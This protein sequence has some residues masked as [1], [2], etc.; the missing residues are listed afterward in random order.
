MSLISIPHLFVLVWCRPLQLPIVEITSPSLPAPLLRV[1]AKECLELAKTSPEPAKFQIIY[2]HI[3]NFVQSNLFLSCWK[4]VKQVAG[5]CE[6]HGKIGLKETEGVLQFR[7]EG[8]GGY[9]QNFNIKVPYMYPEDPLEIIFLKS[10][11]PDDMQRMSYAQAEAMVARCVAGI[12]P[13]Y[14]YQ[15]TQ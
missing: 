9:F 10:H 5:L 15:V 3:Y 11:F 8:K 7:L 4:E 2:D 6:G 13:D 14:S 1:K 12:P